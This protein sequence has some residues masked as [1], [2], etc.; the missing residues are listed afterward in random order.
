MSTQLD[1]L[2]WDPPACTII[3][4]PAA[5]RMGRIRDVAS[6][7]A[8]KSPAAREHYS[9]QVSDG[10]FTH[11]S[12]LGFSEAEQDEFVGAFWSAVHGELHR[13]QHQHGNTPPGAA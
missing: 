12:R 10:L 4:F 2:S 7:M 3:A 5:K 9:R 8:A 6:K 13:R 11:L 1:L